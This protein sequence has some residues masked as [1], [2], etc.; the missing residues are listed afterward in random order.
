MPVVSLLRH[1]TSTICDGILRD[2][3]FHVTNPLFVTQ[4]RNNVA[5]GARF[6]GRCRNDGTDRPIPYSFA[7]FI[8]R[9]RA[10]FYR[11]CL[12]QAHGTCHIM[13]FGL[14]LSE[15]S[16]CWCERFVDGP[17]RVCHNVLSRLRCCFDSR[18][19]SSK[20]RSFISTCSSIVPHDLGNEFWR[21]VI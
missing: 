19:E 11:T 6:F 21:V 17:E 7:C 14:A 10:L 2:V 8:E 9:V 3:D 18:W 5:S 1:I 12:K 13:G 20:F 4:T 16:V 15:S